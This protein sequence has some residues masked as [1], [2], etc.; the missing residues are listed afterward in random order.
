MSHSFSDLIEN[1]LINYAVY[2]IFLSEKS[3]PSFYSV[4][5]NKFYGYKHFINWKND[6][7]EKTSLVRAST[8]IEQWLH[9]IVDEDDR[10]DILDWAKRVNDGKWTEEKF[11]EKIQEK[12]K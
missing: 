11:Q 2:K 1:I 6:F 5:E 7:I 12:L 8:N 3:K 9:E 10:D 4:L